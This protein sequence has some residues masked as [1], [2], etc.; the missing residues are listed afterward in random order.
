MTDL[1]INLKIDEIVCRGRPGMVT[2]RSNIEWWSNNLS[3]AARRVLGKAPPPYATDWTFCGPLVGKYNV[4]VVIKP[5]TQVWGACLE[6]EWIEAD[7]PQRAICLAVIAA[8][9]A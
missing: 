2:E 1:E 3:T 8:H 7:T 6:G 9:K 5:G 4:D